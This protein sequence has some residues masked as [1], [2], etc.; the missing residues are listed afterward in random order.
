MD[1]KAIQELI[2]T[3]SDSKLTLLELESEGIKIKMEKKQEQVIIDR[4]P[5]VVKTIA[6]EEQAPAI[7]EHKKT[8]E[9]VQESKKEG[10]V[11]TS[12]IVGTFYAASGPDA[13]PYVS[14]G[15]KVNKGDVLC[16]I[17]AMKLMNEIESEVDGIITEILVKNEQ[18]VQ[19]GQPLF[20]IKV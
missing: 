4:I 13:K 10:F 8:E 12:P 7:V 1:Y 3:V 6:V 19:Y 18:M 9:K 15:D 17:E 5:E 11:V 20:R 14:V 16:I 2:K